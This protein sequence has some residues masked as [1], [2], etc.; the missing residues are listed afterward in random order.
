M[1]REGADARRYLR[2]QCYGVLSTLS[3]KLDGYPFG[4]MV[5]FMLDHAARPVMY[6]SR[7]AEHTKNIDSDPRASLLVHEPTANVQAAARLTLVGD[8]VRVSDN[9]DALRARY[10]N[11]FP[12]ATRLIAL[13]D[14]AFY[15]IVPLRLRYIGGFG[16]IHWISGEDYA[17]PANQLA[18]QEPEIVAHMNADHA[19][20]LRDFC[21]HFRQAPAHDATMVGIDCDGF[22]ARADGGLLR[23]DFDQPITDGAEARGAL[24]RMAHEARAR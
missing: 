5:P 15:R 12:D 24:I 16:A 1:T 8:A 7:L 2:R 4:S 3:K 6:I 9:L 20:S 21:R 23:F 22:D 10:L 13:G 11:Y 14:F 19:Q 18:A 17:P